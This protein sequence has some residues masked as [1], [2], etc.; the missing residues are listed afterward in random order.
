MTERST[1]GDSQP[2]VVVTGAGGFI[3][4][5]VVAALLETETRVRAHVGPPGIVG[6]ALPDSV[7][8]ANADITDASAMCSIVAGSRAVIHLAG[9]P[10]V[11][12]SF[13]RAAEYAAI[14]VVGTTVCLQACVD[15]GVRRFVYVSSADVYG[16]PQTDRVAEDHPLCA[17]SPYA[18]AKIGAE[19]MVGAYAT[20]HGL[21][22]VILRPFSIYG[23]GLSHYSLLWTILKQARG[24]D[25]IVLSDL[26]PERDYCYVDDLAQ[27]AVRALFA[28]IE[29]PIIVN[30]GTGTGTSVADLAR[31]A[32]AVIGRQAEVLE[33][34]HDKR[35]GDSEIYRLV[36]D[37][38]K[39]RAIL[40]WDYAFDLAAGLRKTIDAMS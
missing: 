25:D 27:A 19:Q 28:R 33:R 7:E 18:A 26:R 8:T 10:S 32:L 21:E 6:H 9:P 35:P 16:R 20:A 39:A 17:R 13:E 3:G 38:R 36:A 22:T 2:A 15:E 29:Q 14:H 11:R 37:P 12:A 40:G 23:P 31:A 24:Q 4:R 34:P 30:I 1:P 5:P